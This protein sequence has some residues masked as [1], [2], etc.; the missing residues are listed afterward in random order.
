[1]PEII[2]NIQEK[3]IFLLETFPAVA[4]IGARQTGKTVLSK[5]LR[6]NWKYVDLEN[7]DDLTKLSQAPG[8]Y[9]EQFKSEIIFDEAQNYPELFN[10]LRGVIDQQRDKKGQFIITGSSSPKLLSH[11]A[12][13]LAGRIAIVELGTLKSNE[14]FG[15]PL[16]P[17]YHLFD[18]ALNKELLNVEMKSPLSNAQMR[19]HWLKGGYP[20]PRLQHDALKQQLWTQNYLDTY[21]NRDLA[22]LFPKLDKVK[23]QRFVNMLS[24][25]S[26]TIIN[27]S[28]LG[29]TLEFNESTARDYLSIADKTF[30]WREILSYEKSI[31]KSVLKMPKGHLR[32]SG[33]QHFL[34]KITDETQ[35]FNSL[36]VGKSFESFVIEEILKG[37]EAKLITNWHPY[38]YRTRRGVEIDLILDG[39]FGTL[40]IEIKYGTSTKLKQLSGLSRFIEENGLSFG[41][42]INQASEPMWLSETIFQLPVSYL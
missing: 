35:L 22:L 30:I 36:Y 7:P 28:D 32:D 9:F 17:F 12:D 14:Y 1:M 20:E 27:K 24:Q 38:Y 5:T 25:L 37:L 13:S 29:R 15:T 10:I 16:N 6:P 31:T 39:M 26:G 23:Y 2:R 11:L 19:T 33:L 42:V 8:L 34:L 18:S 21:I 3:I 41:L 40:P 4:I